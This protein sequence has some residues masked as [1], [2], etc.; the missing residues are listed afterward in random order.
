M[1]LRLPIGYD[2]FRTI[3]QQKLHFVDKSEFIV[4]VLD[5]SA[6]VM[7][8]TRPRRFGKTLNLSMLHHF[9]AAEVNGQSTQYLFDGL[10]ILTASPD[11]LTHQGHYPVISLTLKD[12]QDH[13]FENAYKSLRQILAQ[14]YREHDYLLQSPQLSNS[15]KTVFEA[16]LSNQADLEILVSALQFL[17]YCLYQHT[18][19]NPWI[20]IDEYDSPIQAAYFHGYYDSMMRFM[21]NF[22][23]AA[24]KSN[25]YLYRAVMTGI[26]RIAKESIFSDLNNLKMYSLLNPKYGQY[27]GF[28]EAETSAL[29]AQTNLSH[30]QA[31]IRDWYNGYYI[32]NSVVYNPWSIINCID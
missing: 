31:D 17:S 23:G 7:V 5:D 21:R 9:L 4:D 28:T 16:I 24:L 13:N 26:L 18:G 27:F 6:Q 14:L 10:K 15:S 22:L 8:I 12:I 32:G 25:A 1:T 3:R 29:L 20:L 30:Q 2:N 11:Y 19:V